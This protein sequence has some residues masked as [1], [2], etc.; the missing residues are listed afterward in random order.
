MTDHAIVRALTPATI[1][2]TFDLFGADELLRP[3]G[4]PPQEAPRWRPF[5]VLKALGRAADYRDAERFLLSAYHARD[6]LEGGG[7]PQTE[8]VRRPYRGGSRSCPRVTQ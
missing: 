5:E 8:C 4:S 6:G 3:S 2:H 1:G 7:S